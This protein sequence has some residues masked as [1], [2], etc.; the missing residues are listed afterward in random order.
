MITR[1]WKCYSNS[2]KQAAESPLVLKWGLFGVFYRRIVRMRENLSDG[3]LSDNK[4]EDE[5]N[6]MQWERRHAPIVREAA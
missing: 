6:E 3:L 1:W 2:S 4:K 5:K